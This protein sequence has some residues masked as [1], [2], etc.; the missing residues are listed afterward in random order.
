[1]THSEQGRISEDADTRKLR[2]LVYRKQAAMAY[3]AGDWDRA[4]VYLEK[5]LALD[6]KDHDAKEMLAWTRYQ[7]NRRPEAQALMEEGFDERPSPS[8]AAG[9]L[10]LYTEAGDEDRA[11]DMASARA[12]TLTWKSRPRW[13]LFFDRGRPS[14]PPS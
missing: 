10:G 12:N 11:D 7:Q 14:P 6:P 3:A 8:L 9:L 2:E 1:L 4:A 5:L 13:A